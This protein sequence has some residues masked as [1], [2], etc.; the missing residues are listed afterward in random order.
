MKEDTMKA[1]VSVAVLLAVA[2]LLGGIGRAA[3]PARYPLDLSVAVGEAYA[4]QLAGVERTCTVWLAGGRDEYALTEVT[5][6]DGRHDT[7]GFQ[8]IN[9]AG[10]FAMWRFHKPTS[11]VPTAE[12]ATVIRLV[13]QIGV[14]CAAHWTP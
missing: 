11:G 1:P 12:R 2:L 4:G 8:F 13:R 9:T 3:P 6:K 10:W 5:V 7:G 14:R